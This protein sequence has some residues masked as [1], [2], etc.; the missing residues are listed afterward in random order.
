M[1]AIERKSESRSQIVS[2]LHAKACTLNCPSVCPVPQSH[3]LASLSTS[4]NLTMTCFSADRPRRAVWAVNANVINSARSLTSAL[5][6]LTDIEALLED[7]ADLTPSLQYLS[8]LGNEAC[9]NQLVSPDKDEDDYQRYRSVT[10]LSC[11]YTW[12]RFYIKTVYIWIYNQV[13]KGKRIYCVKEEKNAKSIFLAIKY[14]LL[15]T[16]SL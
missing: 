7:L 10:K 12:M 15:C 8:L 11:F 5:W 6:H 16:W 2:V 13:G 4:V 14:I 9:P 1:K 3:W